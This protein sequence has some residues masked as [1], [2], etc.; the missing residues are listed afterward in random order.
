M[1]QMAEVLQKHA[2]WLADSPGGETADLRGADLR[3]ADLREADLYGADLSGADLSGANLYRANL[4][5][6]NLY[7]ADLSGADL[8]G[9]DLSGANLCEANLCGAKLSFKFAQAYLAPWSVLVTPENITIGCQ[10]HPIVMWLEWGRQ[11]DPKEIHAMHCEARAWWNRHKSIV[12]AMAETVRL[13]ES[14]PI[15]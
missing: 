11:D 10:T 3:E 6:A 2:L 4:C 9:A 1:A 7:G 5:E 8:S 15:S 12:L 14:H 13:N